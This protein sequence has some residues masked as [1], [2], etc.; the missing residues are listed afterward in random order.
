MAS[1]RSNVGDV[2]QWAT[3][4]DFLVGIIGSNDRI[5]GEKS[6]V[7]GFWNP[8]IGIGVGMTDLK[9]LTAGARSANAETLRL[10][11]NSFSSD[12][13]L[14]APNAGLFSPNAELLAANAELLTANTELLT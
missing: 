13:E 3:A 12:T 5:S 8:V 11:P 6:S 2:R 10:T 14:F 4:I 1:T 7:D 9:I